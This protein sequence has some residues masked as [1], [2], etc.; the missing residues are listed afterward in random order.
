MQLKKRFEDKKKKTKG[1]VDYYNDLPGF[2]YN[3]FDL[4]L[5]WFQLRSS[6]EISCLE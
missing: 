6:H 5:N 1:L 2:F 4:F 3:I